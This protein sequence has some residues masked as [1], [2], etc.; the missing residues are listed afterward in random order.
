MKKYIKSSSEDTRTYHAGSLL[1]LPTIISYYMDCRE[2]I[3]EDIIV[4]EPA[5]YAYIA[6][7]DMTDIEVAFVSKDKNK[8]AS[9]SW[10]SPEVQQVLDHDYTAPERDF[11]EIVSELSAKGIILLD[12]ESGTLEHLEEAFLCDKKIEDLIEEIILV[13]QTDDPK[14]IYKHLEHDYI[15]KVIPD[16]YYAD[17]QSYSP[18]LIQFN[19]MIIPVKKEH[20]RF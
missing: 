9:L 4:T 14:E 2:D 6:N 10:N 15:D 3:T 19:N 18:D 5:F 1:S 7:S 8:V 16:L 20:W 13:Y 17:I 11:D 12:D